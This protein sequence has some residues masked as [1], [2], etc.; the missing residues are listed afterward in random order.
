MTLPVGADALSVFLLFAWSF[1]FFLAFVWLVLFLAPFGLVG[2]SLA[3]SGLVSLAPL[4]LVFLLANGLGVLSSASSVDS[5][6]LFVI[7]SDSSWLSFWLDVPRSSLSSNNIPVSSCSPDSEPDAA[8]SIVLSLTSDVHV[9]F[10]CWFFCSLV[11]V[12]V[13]QSMSKG[14]SFCDWLQF[15]FPSGFMFV[16]LVAVDCFVQ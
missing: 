10:F 7:S 8:D 15:V 11:R 2:V 5:W 3:L 6:S 12:S 14:G 9:L 1:L 13:E 16:V 4:G